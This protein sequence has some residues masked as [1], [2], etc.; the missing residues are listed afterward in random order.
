MPASLPAV[1]RFYLLA[2]AP[3]NVI[4]LS[5]NSIS[6]SLPAQW[7]DKG[8]GWGTSLERL[9]LG[10]NSLTG[11]LPQLWSDSNSLLNLA[12]LDL[13]NN[14]LT[15]SIIWTAPNLPKLQSLVLLP[16]MYPI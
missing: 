3:L 4:V 14:R 16:G 15:G 12:R 9:Y 5:N 6:G 2:F 7:A 1:F 10:D 8:M 11:Q 13:F